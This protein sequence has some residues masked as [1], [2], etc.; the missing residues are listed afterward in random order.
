VHPAI[1]LISWRGVRYSVPTRA[2]GQ[3]VEVH[4][5][6]DSDVFTVRWAGQTIATHTQ[7][8]S[9]SDDI[10]DPIHHADAVHAALTAATGR[11]LHPVTDPPEPSAPSAPR[12]AFDDAYDVAPVD[13]TVYGD[14]CGCTGGTVAP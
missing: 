14:G 11:H 12:L 10:W 13:L 1:P 2:L 4:Q 9:G 3:T 5:P 8:P 6:V 7:A